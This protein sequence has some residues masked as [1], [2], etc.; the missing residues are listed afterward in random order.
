[1]LVYSVKEEVN[2]NTD[3]RATQVEVHID[4][5]DRTHRIGDSRNSNGKAK[6]IIVKFTR[7]NRRKK[8]FINKK[9]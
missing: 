1:M 3:K 9:N 5:L 2:E 6:P 8:V 7:Y 4:D